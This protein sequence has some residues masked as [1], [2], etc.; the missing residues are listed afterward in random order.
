VLVY[1]IRIERL[2]SSHASIPLSFLDTFKKIES[3][4]TPGV[5][6]SSQAHFLDI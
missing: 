4:R 2:K 6:I 5:K 1:S 3:K